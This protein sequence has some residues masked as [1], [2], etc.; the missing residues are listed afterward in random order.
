MRVNR[1]KGENGK[2]TGRENKPVTIG[3]GDDGDGGNGSPTDDHRPPAPGP[4]G[5]RMLNDILRIAPRFADD[6]ALLGK[7]H[8]IPVKAEAKAER[9]AA[10]G[11]GCS[12][13]KGKAKSR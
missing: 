13:S 2:D 12:K 6:L 7:V 3:P 4:K 11:E 8:G 9:Q 5:A 10:S 1:L